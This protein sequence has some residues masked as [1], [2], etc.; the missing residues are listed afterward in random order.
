MF[1]IQV[2]LCEFHCI[3][4]KDASKGG[5]WPSGYV[6]TGAEAMWALYGVTGTEKVKHLAALGPVKNFLGKFPI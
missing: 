3:N 4:K 1:Y 5:S 6:V 2:K